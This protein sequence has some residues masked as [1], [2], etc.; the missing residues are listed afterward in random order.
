MGAPG[1]GRVSSG[2]KSH[3]RIS[4]SVILLSRSTVNVPGSSGS[5]PSSLSSRAS[6]TRKRWKGAAAGVLALCAASW[7]WLFDSKP[8]LPPVPAVSPPTP[9]TLQPEPAVMPESVP[10]AL[11]AEV[12][13]P[14]APPKTLK[15]TSAEKKNS[16]SKKKRP[17]K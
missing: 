15:R 11:P 7:F 13:E 6:T 2:V 14:V 12:F 16:G 5:S 4:A 10:A 17:R 9:M 1:T 3:L 8:N